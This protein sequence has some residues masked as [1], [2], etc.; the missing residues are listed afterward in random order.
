MQELTSRNGLT[1]KERL[2]WNHD[3]ASVLPRKTP[4]KEEGPSNR[5]LP[6]DFTIIG[7]NNSQ[8]LQ[9]FLPGQFYCL[10]IELAALLIG[11]QVSQLPSG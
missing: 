7:T 9:L 10:G 5:S 1:G 6:L 3:S 2:R 11:F 4:L 8:E